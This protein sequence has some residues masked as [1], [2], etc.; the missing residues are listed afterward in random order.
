MFQLTR[1]RRRDWPFS[2]CRKDTRFQLTRP[3]RRDGPAPNYRIGKAVS[4]HAPAKAR[5]TRLL[6]CNRCPV[7]THAPAKARPVAQTIASTANVST[8]APAKARRT[9]ASTSRLRKCFNSRAR[10]G[11]TQRHTPVSLTQIVSTHAPAKARQSADGASILNRVST[12][13][14]AKARLDPMD[15]TFEDGGFNSRA[16]EGATR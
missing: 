4:T 9:M 14:P 5:R 15:G 12:H 13:A 6:P 2:E 3:R 11:A 7:S 16:R 1:P 8:H 10:E